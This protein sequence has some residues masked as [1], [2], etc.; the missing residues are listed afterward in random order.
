VDQGFPIIVVKGSGRVADL[1]FEVWSSDTDEIGALDQ[2]QK[3]KVVTKFVQDME[4]ARTMAGSEG[5][6]TPATLLAALNHLFRTTHPRLS[7][8]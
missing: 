6:D 3:L 1:L 7:N 5:L 2:A 4:A 8:E